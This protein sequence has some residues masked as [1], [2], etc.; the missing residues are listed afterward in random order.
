MS[1]CLARSGTSHVKKSANSLHENPHHVKKSVNSLHENL[2]HVKKSANSLHENL[3]HVKKSV[4]SLHENLHH[5]KNPR[6]L[7]MMQQAPATLP[8]LFCLG[9][10]KAPRTV[11]RGVRM[12]DRC[13]YLY[14]TGRERYLTTRPSEF[15]CRTSHH[16]TGVMVVLPSGSLVM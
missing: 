7:Y 5:V 1:S 10:N 3:H 6:I 12:Q 9:G 2:H 16:S 8:R 13:C 14:A 15:V 4:N 11:E